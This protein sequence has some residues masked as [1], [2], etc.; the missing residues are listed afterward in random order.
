[1]SVKLLVGEVL[2]TGWLKIS[3]ELALLQALRGG[4]RFSG[5]ELRLL[6]ELQKALKAGEVLIGER[7]RCVNVMEELVRD[8]I[9]GE[10]RERGVAEGT[11]P[12]LGDIAAYVLNR[13]PPAYATTQE[14]Y[15]EQ[16][17]RILDTASRSLHEAVREAVDRVLQIPNSRPEGATLLGKVTGVETAELLKPLLS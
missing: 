4:E 12:D 8:A 1:M 5:P 16:R 13:M 17:A 6:L 9:L 7:K 14:G 2:R 11:L 15:T 3:Q 10:L